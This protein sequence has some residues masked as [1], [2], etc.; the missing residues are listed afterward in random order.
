MFG[1]CNV[2]RKS[3]KGVQ[4]HYFLG[5]GRECLVF[6]FFALEEEPIGPNGRKRA[7]G[8]MDYESDF[9]TEGSD[10]D[11]GSSSGSRVSSGSARATSASSSTHSGMLLWYYHAPHFDF[12]HCRMPAFA[13]RSRQAS[14]DDAF[15]SENART[16]PT[17]QYRYAF[18]LYSIG[19]LP[20]PP[21]PLL[22]F[23][24]HLH[25][26]G[27][28]Y[29]YGYGYGCGGHGHAM[30]IRGQICT[31]ACLSVCL[32]QN[33]HRGAQHHHR[34]PTRQ[35]TRSTTRAPTRSTTRTPA[36][37]SATQLRRRT[38]QHTVQQRFHRRNIAML[39]LVRGLLIPRPLPQPPLPPLP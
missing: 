24:T 25:T 2:T 20:P 33:L 5:C 16:R 3:S 31:G 8:T 35:P 39:L 4:I 22:L 7:A 19:C 9:D 13:R 12:A 18:C 34:A 36:P 27:Y 17:L 26:H 38:L 15:I 6:H 23:P 11:S 28:G 14:H 32:L 29:G 21:P 30:C 10:A 1:H 37:P